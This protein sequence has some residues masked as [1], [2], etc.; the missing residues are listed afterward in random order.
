[1]VAVVAVGVIL[2]F[3]SV[4]IF[5]KTHFSLLFLSDANMNLYSQIMMPQDE[6]SQSLRE[7]KRL[8]IS[9]KWKYFKDYFTAK[10][11]EQKIGKPKIAENLN[12]RIGLKYEEKKEPI[13]SKTKLVLKLFIAVYAKLK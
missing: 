2:V 9:F 5:S 3:A 13:L 6:P 8:K 11:L 7:E 4:V 10:T 12:S 1:M